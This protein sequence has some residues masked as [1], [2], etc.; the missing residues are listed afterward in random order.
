MAIHHESN[1]GER[2]MS[3]EHRQ[4]IVQRGMYSGNKTNILRKKKR[5]VNK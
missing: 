4:G 5:S 2:D 1:S 3:R